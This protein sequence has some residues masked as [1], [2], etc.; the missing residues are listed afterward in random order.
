MEKPAYCFTVSRLLLVF[1]PTR[2]WVS[3]WYFD[4]PRPVMPRSPAVTHSAALCSGHRYSVS[5]H[6]HSA[7]CGY[8]S[9]VSCRAYG[10]LRDAPGIEYRQGRSVSA[11]SP[12][13]DGHFA[14]AISLSAGN[15]LI[16]CRAGAS[17]RH[18]AVMPPGAPG[19]ARARPR[20][21]TGS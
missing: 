2:H 17:L 14:T 18:A 1:A 5:F 15:G 11:G 10:P 21:T 7:H 13:D 3:V 4:R 19:R 8:L 6:I 12:S 9:A 20:R 16:S